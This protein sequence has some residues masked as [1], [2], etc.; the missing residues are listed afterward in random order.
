MFGSRLAVIVGAGVSLDPPS[1]LLD[2]WTF[3]DQVLRR[4]APPDVP[5]DWVRAGLERPKRRLSRPGELLRFELAMMAL[6][7]S[8]LDDDLAVLECLARCKVPNRNHRMLAELARSGVVVLTTNFDDLIERAYAE[9]PDAPPLHVGVFD[10][11]FPDRAPE[12]DDGPALWKL[13]GSFERDGVD[14]R[15]SLQATMTSVLALTQTGRRYRFLAAVLEAMDVLV[16]G[17]SGWDDFDIVPVIARTPSQRRL[18][19]TMHE[20]TDRFRVRDA[21]SARADLNANW[22]SDAVGLDRVLLN[23]DADGET[24][25]DPAHVCQLY[26]RTGQVLQQLCAERELKLPDPAQHEPYRFGRAFPQETEAFFDDWAAHFTTAPWRRYAFL[27]SAFELRLQRHDARAIK[28]RVDA[29]AEPEVTPE[30]GPRDQVPRLVDLFNELDP[31]YPPDGRDSDRLTQLADVTAGL[32]EQLAPRDDIVA[33]RLLGCL[34]YFLVSTHQSDLFF[35][36]SAVLARREGRLGQ[37]LATLLNWREFWRRRFADARFDDVFASDEA[38]AFSEEAGDLSV[39]SDISLRVGDTDELRP[40][41]AYPE[42]AVDRRI[43]QLEEEIGYLPRVAK[44]ELTVP[45][46]AALEEYGDNIDELA[47]RTRRFRRHAVDVGDVDGEAEC[48]LRLAHVMRAIAFRNAQGLE[49]RT[50]P[51]EIVEGVGEVPRSVIEMVR[52]A[53]LERL[54]SYRVEEVWL[55]PIPWRDWASDHPHLRRRIR[56]SMWGRVSARSRAMTTAHAIASRVRRHA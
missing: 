18:T 12:P 2:G 29:H 49:T 40:L 53:E 33:L 21:R 27:R 24:L 39:V 25:R 38:I 44:D 22:E 20:D 55:D 10:A 42:D 30:S 7:D 15:A 35:V 51:F 43:A 36:Q 26:G 50:R 14:T 1:N 13:H 56:A 8:G 31:A 52:V 45:L 34:A 41:A 32:R 16:V 23:L 17:Y 46:L 9:L 11:E 54:M 3:M 4:A 48:T 19:W 47:A 6:V 28:R 5:A 37:E